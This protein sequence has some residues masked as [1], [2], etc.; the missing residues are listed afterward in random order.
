MSM[1]QQSGRAL[2]NLVFGDTLLPQ[3]FTVGMVEPQSEI[4]VL[5]HGMGIPIDVTHRHS[6]ACSDPFTICIAFNGERRPDNRDLR[7]LSLRFCERDGQK[8]VLGEIGLRL[9]ATVSVVGSELLLFGARSSSNYCLPKILL[10]AHYLFHAYSQWRKVD[11]SDVKMSFLDRRAA[12][13]TFIRPHPVSLVSL[14]DESGGNIFPMNLMG[15]LGNGRFGFALKDSRR[16]AHL[17]EHAGRVAVSSVPLSQAPF[18][19][20]LAANHF[21]QSIVWDQLPF[22]IR[23]STAF[24]IPVPVFTQR[25]REMEIEKVHRVGSHTFFVARIVRDES[26]TQTAGLCVIHGFY[27]AWRLR[28]RKAEL[29]A[30]LAEDLFN[31][32][33]FDQ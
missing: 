21:K 15:D 17:V 22:A 26:F 10:C 11:A 7:R 6:T 14:V 9:T 3:E 5:L 16:A 27:Q 24:H 32:R 19:F 8:R 12:I 33:A 20:Q 2:K 1:I 18:V 28:G 4:I 25:V 31:K 30:S 23:P 13:V 29:R